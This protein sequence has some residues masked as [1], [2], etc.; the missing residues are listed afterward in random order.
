MNPN[1]TIMPELHPDMTLRQVLEIK[2]HAKDLLFEYGLLSENRSV[3]SME[4]V[5]EACTAHGITGKKIEE[6]VEKLKTL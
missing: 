6:L 1:P 3:E 4:T 2:P 5:R